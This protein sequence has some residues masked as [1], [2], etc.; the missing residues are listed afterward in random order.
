VRGVVSLGSSASGSPAGCRE[1]R[2]DSRPDRRESLDRLVAEHQADMAVSD[3]AA[4]AAHR[5]GA[6][7]E[8]ALYR[9]ADVFVLA[10]SRE[11]YGTVWGEAMASGLPVIGWRVGNLPHL[12]KDERE[13]LL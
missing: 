2:T 11:P 7:P 12:A 10:A 4:P 6:S 8:A 13:G 1:S 3:L 5:R 9:A